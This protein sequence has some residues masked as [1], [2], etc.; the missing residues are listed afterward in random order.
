MENFDVQ[1]LPLQIHGGNKDR[2]SVCVCIQSEGEKACQ[3]YIIV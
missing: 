3:D 1:K 2:R